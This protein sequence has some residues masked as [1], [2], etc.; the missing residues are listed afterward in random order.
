MRNNIEDVKIRGG[1]HSAGFYL[2]SVALVPADNYQITVEHP[3]LLLLTPAGAI[4]VLMPT[5]NAL[6]AGLTF[7]IVNLSANTITLKT[8][9]DAAFAAAIAIASTQTAIVVCTGS[10]TQ[11]V[12]WRAL[13]AAGTQ[14][15]P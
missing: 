4:D 3:P 14:T 12:G 9:G 10:A 8:D 13:T 5:S 7:I 6:R 11:N 15:S 1:R 2:D